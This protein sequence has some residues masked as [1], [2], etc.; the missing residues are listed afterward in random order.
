MSINRT[1]SD[2]LWLNWVNAIRWPNYCIIY[3]GIVH[4]F[5]SRSLLVLYLWE[6][7]F[8]LITLKVILWIYMCKWGSRNCAVVECVTVN[9]NCV[10]TQAINVIPIIP[11]LSNT[12]MSENEKVVIWL[13]LSK[14]EKCIFLRFGFETTYG[15][16]D[17]S[18]VF[19]LKIFFL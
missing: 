16:Y 5:N 14:L 18:K 7:C 6:R 10:L 11:P 13:A 15:G 2:L 3:N 17:C 1:K 9:V 12:V 8:V 4:N 19:P